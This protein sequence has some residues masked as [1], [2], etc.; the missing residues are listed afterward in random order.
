M[1]ITYISI[2][3]EYRYI[4]NI[5]KNYTE[6]RI[7][8]ICISMTPLELMWLKIISATWGIKLTAL[9]QTAS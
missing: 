4:Q 7:D 6:Y 9:A 3:N 2:Y 1:F 5:N 8:K